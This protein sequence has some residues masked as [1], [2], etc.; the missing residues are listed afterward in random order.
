MVAPALDLFATSMVQRMAGSRRA[1]SRRRLPCACLA[2]FFLAW[3]AFF[4]RLLALQIAYLPQTQVPLPWIY[5][6][7]VP[8]PTVVAA[9]AAALTQR[10]L[11]VPFGLVVDCDAGRPLALIGRLPRGVQGRAARPCP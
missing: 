4:R 7:V 2:Y 11:R 6:W 9:P 8:A 1:R 3:R 10:T 5:G